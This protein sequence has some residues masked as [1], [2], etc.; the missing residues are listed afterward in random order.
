MI[1][2]LANASR[3]AINFS[4]LVEKF[5]HESSST[6]PHAN[7][8]KNTNIYENYMM[9]KCHHNPKLT[10]LLVFKELIHNRDFFQNF[11]LIKPSLTSIVAR[12]HFRSLLQSSIMQRAFLQL[13]IYSTFSVSH[14]SLLFEAIF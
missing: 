4:F 14:R 9:T 2:F 8:Y 10:L 6:H 12:F 5:H 7:A 11:V 3:G 1:T 13:S